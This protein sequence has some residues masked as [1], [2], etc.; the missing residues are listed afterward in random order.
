V[1]DKTLVVHWDELDQGDSHATGNN[2]MVFAGKVDG[3]FRTGRYSNFAGQT[4]T[5]FDV[6]P[7]DGP[8][9]GAH[10]AADPEQRRERPR[11]PPA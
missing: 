4:R 5:G 9:W 1:W 11:R 10:V 3:A 8:W 7:A 6:R 2:P